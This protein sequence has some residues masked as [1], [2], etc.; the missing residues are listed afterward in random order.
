MEL[1]KT[2]FKQTEVGLI[3]EDWELRELKDIV[4]I[5]IDNRGKTPPLSK[6]EEIELIE[7]A[8]ISFVRQYPDYRKI[9]KF[10]SRVT[11]DIWFRNHPKINDILV[12]TV[13]EY[14]GASAIIRENRGTIAQN[15]IALRI[16][17]SH[18]KYV[19]NWTRSEIF[20]KQLKAVMMGHAQPSLRVPWLLK[21][22]IPLPPSVDEQKA[23]ATALSDVDELIAE[24]EKLIEKKKAIKQGA[25]QALLMPPQKGGKRL[26][27]FSG[28]WETRKLGEIGNCFIGLTYSPSNIVTDGTLVLRS[29]NIQNNKLALKD[30][31]F[32]NSII[33]DNLRVCHGDILICVR[34]GSRQLIGKCALLDERIAGET[35][36]AFMSIYRTKYYSFIFQVLQSQDIKRQIDENLGATINQITN[37][38]LNAFVVPFPHP[39]EQA[40]IS[41]ILD[42]MDSEILKLEISMNKLMAMK[43]GMMQELLT[44]RTRLV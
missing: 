18:P 33:P 23:I 30:N 44:G 16:I 37:K 29:S 19:F 35:F 8:S 3:P 43:Q 17:K 9:S 2:K 5:I 10:V 15:L 36:G 7:T 32:V 22:Q 6:T 34:N 21:F 13:G 14:S 12:S 20:N 4:S 39:E 31:V 27:G 38:M 25:M 42:G 24:L 1:T 26:E 41:N 11:F 28:E 40:A